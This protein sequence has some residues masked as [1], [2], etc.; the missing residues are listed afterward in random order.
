M[1][2]Q[3]MAWVGVGVWALLL[4]FFLWGWKRWGDRME[5]MDAEMRPRVPL[6]YVDLSKSKTH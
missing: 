6:V 4:V 1:G 3:A 2:I 5:A